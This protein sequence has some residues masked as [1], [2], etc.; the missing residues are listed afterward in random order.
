MADDKNPPA[1]KGP[2]TKKA[3][4]LVD[5]TIDGEAHKPDAV[6]VVDAATLAAH[7]GALDA[8]PAAVKYAESLKKPE[9][10]A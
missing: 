3:R 8:N 10:E 4:V 2:A 1:D 7:V 5:I 9:A 6:V